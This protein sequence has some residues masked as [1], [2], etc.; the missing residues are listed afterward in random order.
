VLSDRELREQLSR[1][2]VAAARRNSW[3][4][5]AEVQ[6]QIYRDVA[7]RTDATKLSTDGS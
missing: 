6:E 2:G 1:G 5:V 7:S 4:R 3:D